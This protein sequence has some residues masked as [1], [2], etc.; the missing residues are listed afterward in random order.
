MIAVS[1]GIEEVGVEI[2]GLFLR[3]RSIYFLRDGVASSTVEESGIAN[4]SDID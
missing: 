1:I 3:G 2:D 4:V